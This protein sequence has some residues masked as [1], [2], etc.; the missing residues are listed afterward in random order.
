MPAMQT[1]SARRSTELSASR[2]RISRQQIVRVGGPRGNDAP[3]LRSSSKAWGS[4]PAARGVSWEAYTCT[5]WLSIVPRADESAS[6]RPSE[7]E[8]S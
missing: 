3:R 4:R 7:S 1:C 6:W 5:F 8:T 2:R